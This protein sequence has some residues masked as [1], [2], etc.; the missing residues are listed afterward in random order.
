VITPQTESPPFEAES[1]AV[2]LRDQLV[3][4]GHNRQRVD[5]VLTSTLARFRSARL[6]TF[7]P[8]LV[9]RSVRQA[10]GDG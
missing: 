5:E 9:E 2:E 7:V 4:A 6:R 8:I 10:L 1:W 3:A